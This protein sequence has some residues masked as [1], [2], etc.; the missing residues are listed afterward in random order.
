MTYKVQI[1]PAGVHFQSDD[2]LLDDALSQSIPL[3]YS[4]RTGDCGMC[5]AE[6]VSGSVANELGEEITAGEI[7]TCQCKATSDVVLNAKYY[8]ELISIKQQTVPCKV[9]AFE[10]VTDDIVV[11]KFRFPPTVKFEFLAGQYI[12]LSYKGIKRSYSIAN[13]CQTSKDIELHIRRVPNGKMSTPLFEDLCVNQLMRMEGPKG[14]FFIR[15][16][17]KS[18]I[19]LAGGTGIAPVKAIIESLVNNQD[20]R[21][22]FI[23]WGMVSHHDFY[24]PQLIELA[25]NYSNIHYIPVAS[26]D[27]E[28]SGRKGFVH[29]AVCEDFES[30]DNYEVYA[31]GSSAMIEAAKNSFWNRNLP[32]E[33]F[34]SDVFT[35]AK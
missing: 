10:Y 23:Y 25:K 16:N 18:L 29:S 21:E 22:I 6:V 1:Q 30:L 15:N 11:I 20:P 4:C 35:P 5:R 27:I 8:P 26:D 3:E 7:L 34:Y 17:T 14:T 2:N 33:S 12:D 9:A 32:S 13:A 19:L 31:C 24:L 28:W